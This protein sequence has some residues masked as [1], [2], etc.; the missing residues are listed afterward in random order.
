M[1]TETSLIGVRLF[2]LSEDLSGRFRLPE[3]LSG[4][5]QAS[6]GPS[7]FSRPPQPFPG[8][9]RPPQAYFP[10]VLLQSAVYPLKSKKNQ[11]IKK[12]QTEPAVFPLKS[13][14]NQKNQKSRVS[15]TRALGAAQV[16][17]TLVL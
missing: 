16:S 12:N 8:L 17:E 15:E 14:K 4:P 2:R 13:K 5:P 9:S 6:C 3:R 11:K 1:C 7:G 10:G